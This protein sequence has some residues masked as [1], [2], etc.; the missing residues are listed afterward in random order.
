MDKVN[1]LTSAL[2]S[3]IA[4]DLRNRTIVT[5]L[6]ENISA[7]DLTNLK[8][9]LVM[10]RQ[11][12]VYTRKLLD[13]LALIKFNI[14]TCNQEYKAKLVKIHEAVQY[15]TAIP[16]DRVFVS[17]LNLP[18]QRGLQL[19][20]FDLPAKILRADAHLAAVSELH[21]P[22]LG[23]QPNQQHADQPDRKVSQLRRSRVPAARRV[24]GA[25]GLGPAR[26]NRR[27]AA[28]SGRGGAELRNRAV[29]AGDEGKFLDSMVFN[30]TGS[31]ICI[32]TAGGAAQVLRVAPDGGG[33]RADAWQRRY[34]RVSVPEGLLR[35][36][37]SRAGGVLRRG[38]RQVGCER[39]IVA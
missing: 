5:L 26:K 36:Q 25:N 29:L 32:Y 17:K 24:P 8:D 37:H 20:N 22:P 6:P 27:Q 38:S 2:N 34:G 3:S 33:R 15:R 11:H 16:T 18:H 12:E 39:F 9:L 35:V 23:N 19:Q 10:Y 7:E 28:D 30:E 21:L 14:D 1:L 13:E 4:Y 31:H